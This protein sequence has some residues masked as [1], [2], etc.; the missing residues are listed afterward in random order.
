MSTVKDGGNKLKTVRFT[1]TSTAHFPPSETTVNDGGGGGGGGVVHHVNDDR[2]AADVSDEDCNEAEDSSYSG[3]KRVVFKGTYPID[4]PVGRRLSSNV[5]RQ[6]Q[7]KMMTLNLKY[8][9]TYP[10]DEAIQPRES[11]EVS[12]LTPPKTISLHFL[13][14]FFNG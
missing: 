12:K 6:Q 11:V 10:I 8:P 5:L 4:Q 1:A 14:L 13:L 3:R 2:N 9:R 7:Q